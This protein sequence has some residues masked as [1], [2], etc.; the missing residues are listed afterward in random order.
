METTSLELFLSD[1]V[2]KLMDDF[3]AIL[4]LRVTFFSVDGERL[5]R[6]KSMCNSG[7]CQLIQNDANLLP[8]CLAMDEHK[9]QEAVR[10]RQV[11]S[12]RC[13]AG[14]HECLAPLFLRDKL[15]GFLMLGQFRLASEPPP[16][17]P[18]EGTLQ[19]K[20]RAEY[21]KLPLFT[22]EKLSSICGWLNTLIDYISVRELAILQTDKLRSEIDSYIDAHLGNDIRL[23]EMAKKLGKSISSLSQFLRRNYQTS[24]KELVLEKR[25]AIAERF[26][27]E[28]PDATVAEAAYAAGFKDQFYFSRLFHQRKGV[29]PGEFRNSLRKTTLKVKNINY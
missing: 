12:Y 5:R 22:E 9:R 13:H 27:K 25:L 4:E 21:R 24:F 2:Q 20:L 19:E 8:A 14:L 28:Y 15:A 18:L 23:P 26:W 11:I 17:L 1:E 10:K 7:F 3:A 6:G 16:E 29:P